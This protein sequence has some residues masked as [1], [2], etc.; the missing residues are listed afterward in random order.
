MD[1]AETDR[2]YELG[3]EAAPTGL[4][5]SSVRDLNY[6][7][8]AIEPPVDVIFGQDKSVTLIQANLAADYSEADLSRIGGNQMM[9]IHRILMNIALGGNLEPEATKPLPTPIIDTTATS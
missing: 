6:T 1:M 4:H 9:A 2:V 8:V 3:V 5:I 7:E